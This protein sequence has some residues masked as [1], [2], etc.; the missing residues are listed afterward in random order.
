M[1]TPNISDSSVAV[2]VVTW[3]KIVTEYLDSFF[4]VTSRLLMEGRDGQR[5]VSKHQTPPKKRKKSTLIMHLR[6][7]EHAGSIVSTDPCNALY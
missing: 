5:T 2:S 6:R 7:A 3:L 4:D 1:R